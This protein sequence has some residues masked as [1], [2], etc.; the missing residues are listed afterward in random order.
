VRNRFPLHFVENQGQVDPRAAYYIHGADKTLYFG[1][2]G[3][4]MTLHSAAARELA[5]AGSPRAAVTLNGNGASRAVRASAVTLEFVGANSSVKPIGEESMP[6]RFSY[7]TGTREN[8]VVA[9]KSYARL[10][11]PELWPGIDLIY[12]ARLDSVKYFF[13][14]KPG[15]DPKRIRLRYRGAES[16]SLD[17]D[18]KLLIRTALADIHDERPSAHQ[19]IHGTVQ[20]VSADYVLLS[21]ESDD[22]AYGFRIGKYDPLQELVIDPA[23]LVYAGFIGGTGD[24]RA[25]AIAV[26]ADGNAFIT[27][28]TTS[29]QSS[30]PT[31]GALDVTQN[32]GVD[33]FVAKIDPTGSHLLFA[34]FIGGAGDDRGKSIAVDTLGNVYVAGETSSDQTSFPVTIGPD[35]TYNGLVDA[36][37]A[38]INPAGSEL[39]YAGY[40]GGIS[41]DRAAGIAIDSSN[42]AYV[43]GETASTGASFPNGVGVGSISSFDTSHNGDV[44]AFVVRVASDGASLEYAGYIGGTGADRGVSIAVDNLKRAYIT[45]E[46]DSS[47]ASFPDGLGMAG[48]TTFDPTINGGVDAFV[49]RVASDGGS[50]SYA[51]YIGGSLAD[52]GNGIVADGEGG[53]YI[54]GETS[55]DRNSF[56]DGNG[57]DGLPGPGQIEAGGVDA[58]VAKVNAEGNELVYAGF[59]GGAGDDR[60]NAIALMPGCAFNC[61]VF[62]TGE[63]NSVESS[64]P[65][66]TGPDLTHNGGVDAFIAKVNANGSLGLAGYIGGGGDDRGRGIAV[67][68]LGDVYVA[69]ETNSTQSTFPI[70]GALDRTH[71]F[72]FDAFAA[73]ICVAICA[74]VS[75]SV[76]DSLDPATVGTDVTYTITVRNHGPDIAEDVELIDVLPSGVDLVSA[77]ATTGTCTGATTIVCDLGDLANGTS[78]TVTIVVSTLIP[79][80]LTNSASVSSTATDTDPANNFEQEQTLVTLPNLV[81]KRISVAAAAIPGSTILAGDTTVNSGKVAAGASITQFY[82]STDSRFDVGDPLIGSRSLPSLLPKQNSSG[83]TSLTIPLTTAVGRYFIIAVADAGNQV[84]EG[85]EKNAKARALN[86]TLPDLV[87]SSLRGPSSAAAGAI[88][89]VQDTTS[90]KAPVSAVASTTRYYLSTDGVLDGGDVL[91]TSRSV[92][93]LGAKARS[94]GSVTVTIPMSTPPGKYFLLSVADA[95]GAVSEIDENNNSRARPITVT[96]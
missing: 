79:G 17:R 80:K 18:G 89:G 71:N 12:T 40:I 69:G 95:A 75:V 4:T 84:S 58:F 74:D 55:S 29:L 59:I 65:I 49:V 14:V 7:F 77:T 94:S 9:V 21:P 67:D 85:K 26:D 28:E 93:E 60:G 62:I 56:P 34:G 11:Y 20:E 86:I 33:A 27:G 81:V 16:V 76:N 31:S 32:G 83:S 15:A 64:F 54:T 44:D 66:S 45:G 1:S 8:W 39:F 48:L 96:P 82:L 10:V 25:N 38:K 61:D 19:E 52:K 46:T 23:I 88:L 13:V 57:L 73:K 53:A 68:P 41:L 50:L 37:V 43:T 72:G 6:A 63:T 70:K 90:N 5:Q 78:A 2:A 36:F 87:I 47:G 3:V 51:G 35:L 24:D 22:H 92:P 91:L 30:F 42:R